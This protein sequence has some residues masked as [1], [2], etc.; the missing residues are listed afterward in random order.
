MCKLCKNPVFGSIEGEN[1]CFKK[2]NKHL[3]YKLCIIK[4]LAE[5]YDHE[6]N[7]KIHNHKN[8]E[9]AQL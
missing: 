9:I 6:Y 8:R 1:I 7:I 2:Q 4:C 5:A 3:V